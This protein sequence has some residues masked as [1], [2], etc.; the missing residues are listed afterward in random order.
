M[1]G[2][3]SSGFALFAQNMPKTAQAHMAFVRAKAEESALDEKTS[4]L[5]YLAVLA[6]AGL[7]DGIAFHVGLARKAGATISFDPN[8]REELLDVRGVSLLRRMAALSDVIF[9]SDGELERIG[10]DISGLLR[11][12]VVVCETH[13]EQGAT[14]LRGEDRWDCPALADPTEVVDTDGAGDTFAGAFVAA[15]MAGLALPDALRIASH[16]VARAV[17]VPGPMTV[18]F[19]AGLEGL[20]GA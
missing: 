2:P 14:V 3:V 5:A 20:A 4:H 1:S 17:T 7:T 12:G 15:S 19:E 10:M 9:P 16:A 18:V 6:A 11:S 8:L 13:A